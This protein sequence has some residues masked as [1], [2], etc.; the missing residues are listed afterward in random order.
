M[1][2]SRMLQRLF[3]G[4]RRLGLEGLG[5]GLWRQERLWESV[6]DCGTGEVDDLH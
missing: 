1:C 3:R 2:R 4:V 6:N 5:L